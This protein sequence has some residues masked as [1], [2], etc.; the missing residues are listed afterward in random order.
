MSSSFPNLRFL[1]VGNKHNAPLP[2]DDY[3]P[4]PGNNDKTLALAH[5]WQKSS[6]TSIGGGKD[7]MGG[8]GE[9]RCLSQL[10]CTPRL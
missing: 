5:P 7:V 6:P 8:N 2:I 4:S 3:F 9:P 10:S 1:I